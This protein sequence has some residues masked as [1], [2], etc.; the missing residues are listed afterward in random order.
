MA[1]GLTPAETATITSH[2]RAMPEGMSALPLQRCVALAGHRAAHVTG[3]APETQGMPAALEALPHEKAKA[4]QPTYCLRY[5]PQGNARGERLLC[6]GR[7][8]HVVI[9]MQWQRRRRRRRLPVLDTAVTRRC[10]VRLCVPRG[11]GDGGGDGGAERRLVRCWLRAS[12]NHDTLN[13]R[14]VINS[15]A[16]SRPRASCST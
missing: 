6:H 2:L 5:G 11:C 12:D 4:A 7:W 9:A 16:W 10:R 15:A 3:G 13:T 8:R 1:D 14:L